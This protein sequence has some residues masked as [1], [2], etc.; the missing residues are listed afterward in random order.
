MPLISLVIPTRNEEETIAECITRANSAFQDMGVEG[1][2]VVSDNSSDRTPD[3]A[4]SMGAKVVTPRELGYGNAYLEGFKHARG[5]YIVILDGDLTY[6]PLEIPKFIEPLKSGMADFVMGT[7]LKGDIKKG[8]MPALHRYIGNPFLTR[9]L[10][11]LFGAGISDSHCGMRAITKEALVSLNLHT[12]GM[13]FASEMVIEASRKGLKITEIPISYYSRRGASK[14]SS[15]SDGWRHLRFMMLYKPTPFLLLPG[16]IVLLMGLAIALVVLNE[17][18]S[19]EL[20]THSLILGSL[21]L[22]MGYQLFLSG[23]HM[24]AFGVAYGL[25]KAGGVSQKLMSYH[26]LGWE[27]IAGSTLLIV[28]VIVGM[29]V[30][31]EWKATGYGALQ[32]VHGAMMALLL[33]TLGIQTIFSAIFISLLLL[34]KEE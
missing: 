26:S 19:Q 5:K 21:L 34:H 15:F 23:I 4:I 16:L 6:D 24:S 1:E 11:A 30:I 10:N 28:G 13:E 8:A 22:I 3:I 9:M 14:L 2:I 33:S 32:E 18:R 27:L 20:R 29:S 12:V 31:F 25:S 7:R 17:G